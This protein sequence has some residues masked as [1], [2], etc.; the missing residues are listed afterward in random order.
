MKNHKH[1][2]VGVFDSGIG[3]LTVANAISKQL[4]NEQLIYFGDTAHMPYG[5]K[6][7]ELIR[8]Y[9]SRITDFLLTEKH[10]KAIVIACNTA[11]AAAYEQLR[12]QFKGSVPVINVI[13]PMIEAVIAD[14]NIKKVGIIATKTTISSNVYQEKLSRRKPGLPFSAV[15]TPLLASMIEEGYYN[16]NIS[17]AVLENYLSVEEL[18]DIDALVLACTH[19]P[20]IKN[21]IDTF[22]KHKV[23]IFDSAEVVA[24][25]LKWVLEKEG[26]NS[27]LKTAE[28]QF[29]VSDY[30]ESFARTTSIFYGHE[31][32][33]QRCNIWK[34]D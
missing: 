32:Q 11:S 19:Y 27:E 3:G 21:E 8:Q 7:K 5:D 13:D 33:L 31:I 4:P 22:Y 6:S 10:C 9:A 25:K 26:L 14:N 20:L 2:P 1:Q 12:D 30:T 28:D 17:A 16:D 24:A 23:K 15:A 34:N 18:K 29:Y